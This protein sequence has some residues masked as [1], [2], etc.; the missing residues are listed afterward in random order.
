MRI[1]KVLVACA[2]L[3]IVAGCGSDDKATNPADPGAAEQLSLQGDQALMNG[4][5]AG[6][7]AYYKNALT[8][9]PTH[10]HANLGA[11]VTEL[12][13]LESD[14][15]IT[16]YVD[17]LLPAPQRGTTLL[18][19][20]A[21]TRAMALVGGRRYGPMLMGRVLG[22]LVLQGTSD[23]L[24][25]SEVQD[26]IRRRVLP[27]LIY[28]EARLDR[29]ELRPDF[30]MFLTP[31]MTGAP[32]TIEVDLGE[33][34]M[35]DA[36]VNV[37]EGWLGIAVAYNFD[38]P[39]PSELVPLD[40]LLDTPSNAFGKLNSGGGALLSSARLDFLAAHSELHAAASYILAET[41]D[42][43]DDAIPKAAIDT[44]DFDAV[45]AE[46][47]NAYES[48]TGPIDVVVQDYL[49]ADKT[50]QVQLGNF[51]TN[52]ISDW[53]AKLPTHSFDPVTG[54]PVVNDPI[55][56]PD[57]KFNNIFPN[58]TNT[59]WQQLVGPV[60]PRPAAVHASLR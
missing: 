41:D 46:F 44:P 29:L 59:I 1:L 11:A 52:P 12:A 15:E 35:L 55:T 16:P 47:D 60:P 33:I 51:F 20:P 14:P 18:R 56:F 39:E 21:P 53:K 50:I 4:D 24:V 8:K 42:Q 58:L 48:L 23:P 54:D 45:L 7:N 36:F 32:D 5:Y 13:L 9:D 38:F 26:V 40:S 28:A 37:I 27:R 57:P 34:H 17:P 25:L 3:S 43:A 10:E 6:A 49:G 19:G 30:A 22:R 31:E 2:A